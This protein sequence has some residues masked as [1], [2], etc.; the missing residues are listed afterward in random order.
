MHAIE[1]T[2]P[3]IMDTK[4]VI[5]ITN[6]PPYDARGSFVLL[7]PNKTI[8]LSTQNTEKWIC[9]GKQVVPCGVILF[10]RLQNDL[11]RSDFSGVQ[12]GTNG[13]P[14]KTSKKAPRGAKKK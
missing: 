9:M 11:R 6:C 8:K 4:M 2:K 10:L 5:V 7:R 14:E 1:A 13:T 3:P 12:F